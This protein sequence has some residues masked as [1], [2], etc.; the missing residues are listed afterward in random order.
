MIYCT[1]THKIGRNFLAFVLIGILLGI[2]SVLLAATSGVV[3]S[4]SE[5][6]YPPL[7][8]ITPDGKAAGF[9]VE[10]LEET[11]KAVGRNVTFTVG[12]WHKIRRDLEEGRIQVLP[13]VA[14]SPE[15]EA[16]Y[17]FT[18]A[19][20]TLHGTIIR[21]KGDDRI[22]TVADLRDKEVV[23]MKG[24]SANEY[25]VREAISSNLILTDSY[26]KAMR[27]LSEGQHDAVIVQKLMGLQLIYDLG[28]D[29]LETVG[30]PLET[31]KQ[32]F[33]F[34]V[35]EGDK[36]LLATLNE[37]LS[38]VIANGTLAQLQQKWFFV[39][40]EDTIIYQIIKYSA[41]F[42]ITLLFAGLVAY[43]WQTALRRKVTEKTLE[44]NQVNKELIAEITERQR[45][46][47]EIRQLNETLEQR[48]KERTAE[49]ALANTE[50]QKAKETAEVAN[51]T[52]SL[53]LANMSHELR[54]P[55]NAILGFSQ[56]MERDST[57]TGAQQTNLGI[58]QRSGEH[59]LALIND[60]LDMSKIEAGRMVI[61]QNS[62]DLHQTLKDIT[63]MIRIR[64]QKK[65]L[66]FMWEYDP[67][68]ERYVRTDAGKLRQV[69]INLL[70]NAIKYTHEGGVALRVY[71]KIGVPETQDTDYHVYFEIED[72]GMGIAP[73]ELS[74]IF[75]AFVQVSSSKGVSEGTGL[76]LAITD[77]YVQLMGGKISVKS[78][79]GVGSQFQFYIPVKRV[80]A[81]EVIS[82]VR[83][84]KSVI[85]LKPGQPDYR[86]LL[87]DDKSENLLLLK[88]LL[89]TVGFLNLREADNGLRALEITQEW[90]PHLIWMDMRMPV[91]SGTEATRLIKALP[92]GQ[93][94]KI[95]ALTASA[96][97]EDKRTL[98]ESGCDDF[99]RKPYRENEIF[100]LIT[101][102]LG[103]SYNYAETSSEETADHPSVYLS[104]SDLMSI[105]ET[106]RNTLHQAIIDLNLEKIR[107]TTEKIKETDRVV[108]T[109]LQKLADDFEYDKMLALFDAIVGTK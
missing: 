17:D 95:I 93:T 10:L 32:Q 105:P 11:L 106:L 109:A 75:N 90:R 50:L 72:S 36:E 52:K 104:S 97:E 45:A 21:R 55:L 94:I 78:E 29:N 24:D 40:K 14:R 1:S 101:K 7:A 74:T 64:A 80:P 98:I 47:N 38:I 77:H 18:L 35:R 39:L 23:V 44:L 63:D 100:D 6:D 9:S 37:G 87:V 76:G 102:H 20:L 4:A 67:D 30:P 92:D 13:L 42:L 60:V 8:V 71:G 27:L 51:Q 26:E 65:H 53:F 19:Y 57:I 46:E 5:P 83:N 41:V 31:F 56:L 73:H 82:Q 88:T 48:V 12:P 85:S 22:N 33:C 96:F 34:A 70:G 54:T 25:A 66:R 16:I 108:A 79:L 103:V 86:L 107:E 59:L 15:R 62:F 89:Q 28:I 61:E 91:M 3:I 99:L 58:I 68:L 69:L 81:T 2:H 49:L 84:E 43:F